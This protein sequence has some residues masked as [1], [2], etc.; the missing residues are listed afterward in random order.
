MEDFEK[1]FSAPVETYY[2]PMTTREWECT[3]E[4]ADAESCVHDPAF[5]GPLNDDWLY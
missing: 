3:G 1:I 5:T 2:G 4:C